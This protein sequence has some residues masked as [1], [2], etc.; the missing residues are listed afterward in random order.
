VIPNQLSYWACPWPL[1]CM[2]LIVSVYSGLREK[3]TL[4][5]EWPSWSRPIHAHTCP[6]SDFTALTSTWKGI[7]GRRRIMAKDETHE[8]IVQW[9]GVPWQNHMLGRREPSWCI[10]CLN[11]R[12]KDMVRIINL[13]LHQTQNYF[14]LL[15]DGS[16]QLYLQ[17]NKTTV[18]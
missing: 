3:E 12:W 13:P 1:I 8:F 4:H 15:L 9:F 5:A 7:W 10:L 11:K 2:L 18:L 14:I 17:E 16:F 6:P